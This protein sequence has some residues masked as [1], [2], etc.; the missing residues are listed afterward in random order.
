MPDRAAARLE[1]YLGPLAP[2]ADP[3]SRI[4]SLD[5]RTLFELLPSPCVLLDG[6]LVIRDCNRAYLEVVGRCPTELLGRRLF[7]A[8]PDVTDAG[9]P[10]ADSVRRALLTA[11]ATGRPAALGVHRYDL[12]LPEGHKAARFW[13]STV[14]PLSDSLTKLRWLLYAIHDVSALA[15]HLPGGAE[16]GATALSV[17]DAVRA[18]AAVADQSRLFDAELEA[19]RQLGV[20][21]QALML[22]QLVPDAVTERVAVAVRY[23]PATEALGVGGDWYDVADIGDGRVALAVG[24]VVGHGVGAASVMGQLRT[25]LSAL[26]VADV[27]PA[28]ALRA[29]DRIA[30]T[31]PDATASTA[32]KVVLDPAQHIA[33][34]SSAGHLPPLLAHLDG[35]VEHLDQALGPPLAA[36]PEIMPRPLATAA[37]RPGDVLVMYTDGLVERRDEDID[38]GIQRLEDALTRHRGLPVE[39]LADRLLAELVPGEAL[40]DDVALVVVRA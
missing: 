22:P 7:D 24:D 2:E 16:A 14:V 9:V 36:A 18:A 1:G 38:A 20:A 15:A 13:A 29:L 8:F 25:A 19:G 11:L 33:V 27:G 35:E 21:V 23:R 34:Y 3:T 31:N 32:I 39:D 12:Q 17:E 6:E 10:A 28:N 30:G 5:Y 40:R 4:S 37:V 26:T